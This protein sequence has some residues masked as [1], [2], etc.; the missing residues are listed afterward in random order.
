MS[1]TAQSK[2]TA[3]PGALHALREN[4]ARYIA[5]LG[6]K[7][8][9]AAATMRRAPMRV[10]V[11]VLTA[12]AAVV[13]TMFLIDAVAVGIAQNLP[14]WLIARF[15]Q[16]TDFGNTGWLLVPI[17]LLLVVLAVAASVLP[18]FS[19][20]ILTAIAVRLAFL[21]WAIALPGLIF[22]VVKRLIGRARP[23]VA[24][25][26][27]PFL[28]LPLGWNMEYASLPSG[29]ATDAFAAAMAFGALYPAA[30]PLLWTYAVLIALSRVVLTAHF[31]SDVLAG[32]VIGV[33]SAF[34][35]REWFAAR[36]LAF[37]VD[38][39]G[40]PRPLPGPAFSRIKKVVGQLL[41]S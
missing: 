18:P 26:A 8:K 4:V 15:D 32:A 9:R 41:A 10:G 36:R 39:E 6:R 34:L 11:C 35:V 16:I 30:R 14:L 29:H 33:A 27:D 17:T 37:A 28:Y 21:F 22:T 25:S 3:C 5:L 1:A 31:P 40:R 13:V 19:Q 24:G 23:L 38:F 12:A 7:P 20:R 2:E